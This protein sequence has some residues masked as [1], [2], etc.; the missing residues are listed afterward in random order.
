MHLSELHLKLTAAG[1]Q[2]E[3]GGA[4]S[5]ARERRPPEPGGRDA[6]EAEAH[7]RVAHGPRR[8]RAVCRRERHQRRSVQ[9]G[10][11]TWR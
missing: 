2:G 5:G 8:R 11:S 6:G 3:A 10:Y 9:G 4:A 1:G 7:R